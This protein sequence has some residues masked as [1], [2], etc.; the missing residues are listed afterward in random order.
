MTTA[1]SALS[2]GVE[3]LAARHE[4]ER[5]PG[6]DVVVV[7]SGYGGAVA[8]ARLSG[9]RERG[10]SANFT[11]CVLERGKEYAPGN[12]PGNWAELVGHLRVSGPA[13]ANQPGFPE[14]LFDFK[15]GGDVTVL[16]ASGVGGGSLINAGVC[17]RAEDAVFHNAAWPD[18]WRSNT[19]R[20][21]R[22][23]ERAEMRLGATRWP[24]HQLNKQLA[25]QH[26]ARR[27]GA[28]GER[29][30]HLT[31][32]P[33]AHSPVSGATLPPTLAPCIEC[34]DC[35]T[36]CNVGA[37]IT[38]SHNYLKQAFEQ[39]AEIFT[40]ATVRSVE[41]LP[42]T[43]PRRQ[44]HGWRWRVRYALTN[45]SKLPGGVAE[46]D[47]MAR[48][49][50][51]SAGTFGS[52]EIL[53]RSR[54]R[55]LSVSGRLGE[56]FSGNGD[57]V[58]A[59]Y[60]GPT[61]ANACPTDTQALA[62]R[63][64][65][66]T[67]TSQ[68]SWRP[69]PGSPWTRMTMQ[70]LTVP[71][72]LGW[73][74]QELIT[75]MLVPER[76]TRVQWQRISK[77]AP[78]PYAPD[79]AAFQRTL[80]TVTYVDDGASGRLEPTVGFENLT[81]DGGLV[82]RWKHLGKLPVLKSVDND[83]QKVAK[84]YGA[85]Y[86]RNPLYQFMPQANFLGLEQTNKQ[87][88]SVHPLG[89]CRMADNANEGVTDPYGRVYH[90]NVDLDDP[91]CG[92][93]LRLRLT[94]L[95]EKATHEGL[96]VLDGSLIPCALGINPLLTITAVAEGAIDDW[97]QQNGWQACPAK[98]RELHHHTRPTSPPSPTEHATS[99]RFS[100]RMAGRLHHFPHLPASH[101][102][103]RVYFEE[104]G[105]LAAFIQM[106]D[107]HSRLKAT[108]KVS[109]AVDENPF[110]LPMP[111]VPQSGSHLMKL[112][113]TVHWLTPEPSHVL[114]RLWRSVLT[115]WRQ[116]YEADRVESKYRQRPAL[117][118][119]LSKLMGGTH[120]GAVRQLAYTFNPLHADWPLGRHPDHPSETIGLPK[121]TVLYG[122]KRAGYLHTDPEDPASAN[123]WHQ[124]IHLK[125]HA[126]LPPGPSR[127]VLPDGKV[128]HRLGAG[129]DI[130]LGVLVFDE[131][132]MMDRYTVPLSITGQHNGLTALR[133]LT[134]LGLFFGRTLFGLHMLSFRR[135]EYP[136]EIL[137]HRP[138]NRLPALDH[139][140]EDARY[141]GLTIERHTLS[142]P[143]PAGT[144]SVAAPIQL[145]LTRFKPPAVQVAEPVMLIHGFGSGGIQFTHSAIPDPMAPWL[146]QR[147]CDVWVVELRTSIGLST[148]SHQQWVMDEVA[149]QD[150]P[151]LVNEVLRLTGCRQVNVIAH[152]IGSAMFCM[153]TLSGRLAGKIARASLMQVGPHA[154]LPRASRARGYLGGRLQQLLGMFEADSVASQ[155]LDD[156]QVMVD[157]L[158]GT[159]LYPP[160]QRPHY[161]LNGDL[162]H[163]MRLVS[164]N[165]STNI[166][167]QL[168]QWENMTPEV[169]DAIEDLLGHCNL[170][171]YGQTTQ[172]VYNRRVMDL[173]GN[174]RYLK[175]ENV[176]NCF[177]F[178][179]LLVHGEANQTF[180]P[181]TLT[182]N[183]QLLA[184]AGTPVS[185]C[186]V[187]GY[188][189]LD[190]V[191]GKD[192]AT[193]IY[194]SLL[195][196]L[197]VS[198]P[199][200]PDSPAAPAPRPI[201]DP[202]ELRLPEVGPWLGHVA[203]TSG[204][205]GMSCVLL[206]VGM[207]VE[208]LGRGF[209]GV[210]VT[211]CRNGVPLHAHAQ[212]W[213]AENWPAHEGIID[214][215]I[216]TAWMPPNHTLEVLVAAVHHQ[217]PTNSSHMRTLV[218][219]K[220][221]QL[222]KASLERGV[223]LRAIEG[224][225]LSTNWLRRQTETSGPVRLAL[226]ACR[227]RPL[228]VDRELADRS[229]QHLSRQIKA[230]SLDVLL[231]CGDQIY[232]DSRADSTHPAAT[233]A[234]LLDA[235]REA[236]TSP[237]QRDVMRRI[238]TY[239]VQDDHEYRNDYNMALAASRPIEYRHARD[240]ARQYQ[241]AA[242]PLAT[243]SDTG[244]GQWYTLTCRGV[245][246]FMADV[247]SER[248][249][250][251]TIDRRSA[252]IMSPSQMS[253]LQHWLLETPPQGK[254]RVVVT[255]VPI[256]PLF[257]QALA[258]P[259]YGV[260]S[261]GWERF[262][263]SL[264]Q[265]LSWIA[266]HE[267]HHVVFLSGDY[268]HSADVRIEVQHRQQAIVQVRSIVTGGLYSPY[269]FANARPEDWLDPQGEW[270]PLDNDTHWTYH[271]DR[272]TPGDGYTLVDIDPDGQVRARFKVCR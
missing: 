271:I 51:L 42:P 268:H 38:L 17:E 239:M 9:M 78:E 156:M 196:H 94:G 212:C 258:D 169:M 129:D 112:R 53:I 55:G 153:A 115:Y 12:F 237:G 167:G 272:A 202:I 93:S 60:D 36:G 149:Q 95:T 240:I 173:A 26:L 84:R 251:P 24:R 28:L 165:R 73:V 209:Q 50:V 257:T 136:V 85:T 176:R 67:I 222:K 160:D 267:I 214:I 233:E 128:M 68:I 91:T 62:E 29:P 13:M 166:F 121:G 223:P 72:S 15:T 265:L 132:A 45:G 126:R 228:L 243:A 19:A 203:L 69:T 211:V 204:S 18:P 229:M 7:G 61:Q 263:Q 142:L 47:V 107:R 105:D 80:L 218:M 10:A 31:I 97:I 259:S 206:R 41:P 3:I 256:A 96:Y 89:G 262:P 75:T 135:P 199:L 144:S 170:T 23:Y 227:Q 110:R 270:L 181:R 220:Y 186:K 113:G 139:G 226:G 143:L 231:L 79:P 118:G 64:A 253:A 81:K 32:V 180:S 242:G 159:Y 150:I 146:A 108:F 230:D 190:C 266:R 100:E 157:R 158:M 59:L 57:V 252:R 5:T 210:A 20:W 111:A 130:E 192:V 241:L 155:H 154:E 127:I 164:A 249:D 35:F 174:D 52:T 131:L 37:K 193:L 213:S 77:L 58:T 189:H 215:W 92:E 162:K 247:R 254:T 182:R 14:G 103:M 141:A 250:P 201:H 171:T 114:Q 178:P 27:G 235:H 70:E 48:H 207:R 8:A 188:G 260:R 123:P 172:F 124:L 133:D 54:T 147:G 83:L 11:V 6:Y 49:V 46:Y 236:W 122:T 21:Q 34:G 74:F 138:R 185:V 120:F 269:P 191:V 234:L 183:A 200:E 145:L 102:S 44:Q 71:S 101:L 238:A 116:R 63:K 137:G 208:D 216:P 76:W 117:E 163:N 82:V 264:A 151:A 30:I 119:V 25:M 33:P 65:G 104:V 245:P 4:A 219:R 255:S 98:V 88:L 232:A 140:D 86:F 194:P 106:P 161:R 179:T 1:R 168:F 90:P 16:V 225:R 244:A 187:P 2:L 221:R 99:V 261:D 175:S 148:T 246:V 248:H 224:L 134:R 197:R 39:G 109:Q 22:L 87:T 56:G 152:C 184:A 66:P 43:D 198:P 195:E 125:L 217:W 205:A 40:G 177:N